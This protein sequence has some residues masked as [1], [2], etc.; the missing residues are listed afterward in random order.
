MRREGIANDDEI[1]T[2][3]EGTPAA[4]GILQRTDTHR[5]VK[6]MMHYFRLLRCWLFWILHQRWTFEGSTRSWFYDARH[7]FDGLTSER[8]PSSR[9]LSRTSSCVNSLYKGHEVGT[10]L[11]KYTYVVA[12]QIY[13][14]QKEKK[15]PHADEI[16]YLMKTNEALRLPMLTQVST[17]RDEKEYY[18]VLVKLYIGDDTSNRALGTVLNQ[19]FIIQLGL[20][21]LPLPMIVENSLE[22]GF[23]QAIWDF[24]TMQLQLSSVFYTFSM[25]TASTIL[26]EPFFMVGQNIAATGRGFV[27]CSTR[28]LQRIID[29]MPT[30]D[31]FDDFMNWI[32]YRGSVFAKA[33]Q[34]WERWWYEEQDHLRTTGRL[35]KVAGD[36]FRPSRLLFQ[37]GIVIPAWYC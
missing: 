26:G 20:S 6:G 16:L 19:Q 25:G 11:M 7:W 10:V 36:N 29:S 2:T 28:V 37:Y 3:V 4:L 31:D 8:S 1:W 9:S 17:G 32:W 15:D 5:T 23:L 21:T 18:S 22:H 24:L 30:V 13:G 12:C 34:S 14:T 27:V 35:G 33:E